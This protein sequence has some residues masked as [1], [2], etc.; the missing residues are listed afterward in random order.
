[1]VALQASPMQRRLT[2]GQR[3]DSLRRCT[4]FCCLDRGLLLELASASE[5]CRLRDGE[6]LWAQGSTPDA[7]A[8]VI[9][10][11]PVVVRRIGPNRRLVLRRLSPGD[12]VGLSTLTGGPQPADVVARG[13][14]GFVITEGQAV[15]HVLH[16]HPGWGLRVQRHVADE[17]EQTIRLLEFLLFST[18][19][20]RITH[21]LR[22]LAGDYPVVE[23]T[24]RELREHVSASREN[25]SRALKRLERRGRICCR[26]RRI[27]ILDPG[28]GGDGAR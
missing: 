17:V 18:L 10:G 24:H 15:R 19:E 6:R 25:V 16:T 13:P 27:E 9:E 20:E 26:R 14:V 23:I 5:A 22:E 7:V 12:L 2:R 28:A 8:V 11:N 21:C 4:L 3:I 1:M